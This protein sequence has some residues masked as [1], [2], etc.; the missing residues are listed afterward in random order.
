MPLVGALALRLFAR[1]HLHNLVARAF[2]ALLL[3]PTVLSAFAIAAVQAAGS[4]PAEEHDSRVVG[5]CFNTASYA[6]LARLP[7][8]VIAAEPDFGPFILALTPQSVVAAPYHRLADGIIAA[9][10]MFT[11]PPDEARKVLQSFGATYVVTCG[12]RV[13]P[14]MSAQARDAS[15]WGRLQAGARPPW[16]EPVP[17]G[18]G[19]VFTV[20]RIVAA[21]R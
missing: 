12:K 18:P 5:G 20:Y 13:P 14:E 16:L 10:R 9:H 21:T 4:P 1:L 11:T 7:V 6:Q 15:L 2:A 17:G 8:G 19:D 3:T